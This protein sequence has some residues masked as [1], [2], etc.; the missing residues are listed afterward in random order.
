MILVTGASGFV[1]GALCADLVNR[2]PLRISVRDKSKTELFENVDTLEAS[3]SPDQDW[4]HAL[5]GV[6][7]VVHCAARVHVMNDK[8]ANPLLEFRR[9]NVDG[10][11]NLARQAAKAGARRFVFISSIKV[12]GEF[13]AIGH[14]FIADQMPM[15]TDPYGVSKYEA[16]MG[17]MALAKKTGMDVAIIRSPLVYGPG[18]KANFLS[19]MSWLQRGFPLPL[20][21]V[22]KNRR[23]FVYIDN[24]VSL[25]VT[26]INHP[27]A[28]NQ[29][30]L[31]SDDEDLSTARLLDLMALALG[32]SSKLIA[33]PSPLIALGVRLIGGEN[34]AK[35]LCGS[36]QLDVK[37]TKDLLG[38]SPPVSVDEGLRETAAYFKKCNLEYVCSMKRLFD[39]TSAVFI[40][41][42]LALPILA[43]AIVV[44]FTSSGPSL[45]WSNR[46]G[47]NNRIF[48]MPKFRTMQVGTPAVATHLLSDSGQYLTPV[49]SFLRKSS[50]DELP[51]LWSIFV[52]DMSFVGPRPALFNQD[53]LIALRT[54]YGIDKLVPGL[55]GWAQ[56]NGRDELS[57]PLKVQYEVEYLQKQSFW[58]DM[59]I[60]GLTFL[61]VVRRA[62]VSH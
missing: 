4:S 15:P 33:I 29:T 30:F 9:V 26:C 21:G 36:L 56:V 5:S 7:V 19:M 16:E 47:R 42:M 12:N 32:R 18:V 59:K 6:S 23:S 8:A 20:G 48:R 38:W 27:A 45:Y 57:I 10:T 43:I 11:L 53:D 49:G 28:A 14:P 22:T 25:I 34:V 52:G 13:T 37:K 50:L 51:Q 55:T 1:G 31:V 17:L 60:L 58:F 2:S 35:R 61:K 46:V 3:L 62:G 41:I 24:L 40:A 54:Q 44:R 39:L